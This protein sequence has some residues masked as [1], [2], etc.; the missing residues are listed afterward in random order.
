MYL[1]LKKENISKA[2]GIT[3]E[4]ASSSIADI[5]FSEKSRYLIPRTCMKA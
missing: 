5:E 2:N 3:S 4:K 1:N